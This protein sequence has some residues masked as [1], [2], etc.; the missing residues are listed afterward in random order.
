MKQ[1]NFDFD[2]DQLADADMLDMEL[3]RHFAPDDL[4]DQPNAPERLSALG[5][6]FVADDELLQALAFD[7][8]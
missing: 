3:L 7:L 1:P 2:F 6:Q 8:F 4:P 5:E